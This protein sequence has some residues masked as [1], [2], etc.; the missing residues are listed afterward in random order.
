MY[1]DC[2]MPLPPTASCRWRLDC[3]PRSN[4]KPNKV[5]LWMIFLRNKHFVLKLAVWR[6]VRKERDNAVRTPTPPQDTHI[7]VHP[8]ASLVVCWWFVVSIEFHCFLDQLVAMVLKLLPRANL[9][10]VE[11]LPVMAVDWLGAGRP[12]TERTPQSEGWRE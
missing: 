3:S 9:A 10:S 1:I 6:S 7:H 4:E 5:G 11:P 2:K 12:V 8:Q